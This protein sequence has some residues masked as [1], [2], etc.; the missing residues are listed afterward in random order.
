MARIKNLR[1][2]RKNI[3][4]STESPKSS[5]ARLNFKGIFSRE[6]QYE[7]FL[8]VNCSNYFQ[9]LTRAAK[10]FQNV[11]EFTAIWCHKENMCQEYVFHGSF[12]FRAEKSNKN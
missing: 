7:E 1:N 6:G 3:C 11:M 4:R 12:I 5:T 2:E 8:Y 10:N 9:I